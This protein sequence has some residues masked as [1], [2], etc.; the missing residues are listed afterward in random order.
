MYELLLTITLSI[1]FGIFDYNFFIYSYLKKMDIIKIIL[2]KML[3]VVLCFTDI[4]FIIFIISFILIILYRLFLKKH[5]PLEE[6]MKKFPMH[7]HCCY[8]D[9]YNFLVAIMFLDKRYRV[10][11]III[12]INKTKFSAEGIKRIYPDIKEDELNYLIPYLDNEFLL[13]N[14]SLKH[15]Y[16]IRIIKTMSFWN[17]MKI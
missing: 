11:N 2:V 6:F 7:K 17:E 12:I 1:I 9:L 10:R 8:Y 16:A 14:Y 4:T 15:S 5:V 3:V 13:K